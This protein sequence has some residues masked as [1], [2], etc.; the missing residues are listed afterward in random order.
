MHKQL[1]SVILNVEV[2]VVG[3][4]LMKCM[5]AG[6]GLVLI[7][8]IVGV[9]SGKTTVAMADADAEQANFGLN[10]Y[11]KP[12]G[13]AG[14]GMFISGMVVSM[15]VSQAEGTTQDKVFAANPDLHYRDGYTVYD[16]LNVGSEYANNILTMPEAIAK[17]K[18]INLE[19]VGIGESS[20]ESTSDVIPAGQSIDIETTRAEAGK[21]VVPEKIDGVMEESQESYQYL[22]P[23]FTIYLK[24]NNY[25]MTIKYVM[26]DGSTA[27]DDRVVTGYVGKEPVTIKSP[28]KEGVE[29]DQLNVP[30]NFARAGEFT[31]TVHYRKPESQV[32]PPTSVDKASLTANERVTV[33]V[34]QKVDATTFKATA[35]NSQGTAIPVTV[36]TSQAD[37][38]RPG[39]YPVTLRAANGKTKTVTLVVTAAEAATVAFK[40]SVVYGLKTLYLYRNPTFKQNQRVVKYVKKTRT[41]RPMFVVTGQAYSKAGRLRYQ[42]RDMKTG[43]TGYIT[44]RKAF[45][46]PAYYQKTVKKIKVL[47]ERGVNEYTDLKLTKRVRHVKKNQTL[48]VVGLRQNGRTT[49][50]VLANGHYLTANKKFVM[51]VK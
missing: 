29:S 34:G 43:K 27:F 40:Q 30:V 6:L 12:E 19:G 23:D 36:D 44:A 51:A 18:T 45:V 3:K 24:N 26:P 17:L 22:V 38:Q 21:T 31:T 20:V 32:I 5:V 25:Q 9:F 49:R 39:I 10:M 15:D 13:E 35:T 33:T 2:S 46:G 48:K 42:V 16:E 47:G 50:F 4:R 37:L 28:S 41:K 11:M 1:E 7:S 8:L 14:K